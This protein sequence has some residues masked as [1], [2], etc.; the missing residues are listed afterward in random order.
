MCHVP[1]LSTWQRTSRFLGLLHSVHGFWPLFA[2]G[3]RL[4]CRRDMHCS[5]HMAVGL[6]DL[7]ADDGHQHEAWND[8]TNH[9]VA[10]MHAQL[11][12]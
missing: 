7:T 12:R 2:L 10:L 6:C 4:A 9:A 11:P 5:I 3:S 1:V 8:Q